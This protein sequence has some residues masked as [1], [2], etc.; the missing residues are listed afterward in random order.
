[1]TDPSNDLSLHAFESPEAHEAIASIIRRRSTHREDVREVLLRGLDLSYAREVLD[2]GCGFGFLAEAIAPRI[3]PDACVT[4]VDACAAN[5][6]PFIQRVKAAGRRARFIASRVGTRLP[7]SD[8]AF[9]LILVSYSL[10]F[11]PDALPDLAR[12]LAP[13]GLL[14]ILTHSERSFHGLLVAAGIDPGRSALTSLVGRFSAENAGA[15]LER[16]FE[17]IECIDYPNELRFGPQDRDEILTYLRFKLP[18]LEP[19]ARADDEVPASMRLSVARWLDTH[20]ELVVEKGD[21]GFRCRRPRWSQ[22]P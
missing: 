3:A 17:T 20:G 14:L 9:D 16:H 11:F 1:M 13:Q 4:G 18:L 21:A 7:W 22:R 2:L 8:G 15:L 10:Y 19:G 6:G 5:E 12:V